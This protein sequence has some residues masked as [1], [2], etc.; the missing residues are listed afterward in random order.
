MAFKAPQS[1]DFSTPSEWTG[2][3]NRWKR[4][5]FA[6]KV[7]KETQETQVSSLIYAMGP[8]AEHI[9]ASFDLSDAAAKNYETVLSNFDEYFEPTSNIIATR[10]SFETRNQ[11]QGE[12]NEHYIRA[13]LTV[14]EKCN[15]GPTK[16]ERIRDRLIAGMSNKKLS[17]KI[18]LEAL[19]TDV[20]M[21]KVVTMMRNAEIVEPEPADHDVDRVSAQ[22]YAL[23]QQRYT[24]G[25]EE[26]RQPHQQQHHLQQGQQQ[27]RLQR[28]QQRQQ[29]VNQQGRTCSF[30]GRNWHA[31]LYE[32]PARGVTCRSCCGHNHYERVCLKNRRQQNVGELAQSC[33]EEDNE[34]FLGDV[35]EGTNGKWKVNLLVQG[36]QLNFKVD[37][38]AD[39]NVITINQWNQMRNKPPLQRNNSR[40]T[41][42]GKE[43][44]VLGTF[45]GSI[46]YMKQTLR[47]TFFVID[48][49]FPDNL[50]CRS[51]SS[52]LGLIKFMGN[53]SAVSLDDV[54]GDIG[55]MKTTPV[56]IQLTEGAV[57]SAVTTARAVPL[58][59]MKQVKE[60][61]ARMEN[62]G[63][64][65]P[66][67]QPTD[68]CA[69][70][71][72]VSKTS[73]IR[74]TVDYKNLNK[75]VKREIFPIPTFDQLT[76]QLCGS[77]WFTKLDASS[78][79]YQLPLSEESKL[80]TTFI[81]PFG[82][83]MFNRLPMGINLAPEVFQRKMQE[84]LEGLE[85]VICYMDDM[86]IYGDDSTHDKRLEAVL[87][88]IRTSGLKL[89]KKKCEIKRPKIKFL[90]N[91]ISSEGIQA[92]P[93][94][95]ASI[96]QLQA[97]RNVKELRQQ[98]GM[99]NYLCKFVTGIQT[100]LKPM[101]DLLKKDTVWQWT[102]AQQ[103]AL[104]QVKR[105]LQEA[106]LLAYYDSSRETIVSADA[107]SYG[108]G[109][110]LL[111]RHGNQLKPIAFCSRLLTPTEQRYATIEKEL[112]G[113]TW[114]CE[115][116]RM[117]VNG[118]PKFTVQVD[119]KPLVPLIN[120]KPLT[121]APVRCQRMLMRMMRYNAVALYVPGATH[122]VPD[123]LSRQPHDSPDSLTKEL[124]DDV[125]LHVQAV[126]ENLR[127]RT[128][129]S[130]KSAHL[131]SR[132][133]KSAE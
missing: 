9:L 32:C 76:S 112:L 98:L 15:F 74:I 30:C 55:I 67:T 6:N 122:Y 73:G 45:T 84:M 99:I 13:L 82:R 65:E 88:R 95:I 97:P 21:N 66:V 19:E 72:P 3:R 4:F 127:P 17:K 22:A 78:G 110:C 96:Q 27:H 101:N 102:T 125:E 12:A 64:I 59:R 29:Q 16:S 81:T 48:T 46:K 106:P 2:W 26:R 114:A 62:N 117:F 1:F 116:F 49:N 100:V 71:V 40:V 61:L 120:T 90:G 87:E 52:A 89:N 60:E 50:L 133:K 93:D 103:E 34:Y 38:G 83:K 56:T 10:Q 25:Y 63:I 57:P 91:I 36:Q 107:S 42:L 28:G 132:M 121:D 20:T 85:G 131:N 37:S 11:K 119:H 86:V 44:T 115:K 77:T 113:V 5:R 108:I 92:D 109:G 124:E 58:P 14:A 33:V 24:R 75:S 23:P 7:N 8:E 128:S 126:F 41:S 79:F 53:V 47:C 31:S 54:F 104:D 18:Q 94:K 118:L 68:W 35:D 129:E 105:M 80:L 43:L 39:V 123:C 111:Q 130:K 69:P 51:T 70:M